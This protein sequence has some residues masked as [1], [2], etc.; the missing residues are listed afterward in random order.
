MDS[1]LLDLLHLQHVDL[2][3][4]LDGCNLL[5]MLVRRILL[6]VFEQ[7]HLAISALILLRSYRILV[8]Q[9]LLDCDLAL[10]DT[11]HR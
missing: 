2:L 10:I 8:I 11:R 4:L 7:S 9:C 1:L 3:A 6:L 5:L